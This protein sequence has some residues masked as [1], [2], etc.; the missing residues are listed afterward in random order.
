MFNKF[1]HKL[2]SMDPFATLLEYSLVCAL[3]TLLSAGTV[4]I[5]AAEEY[6]GGTAFPA[7]LPS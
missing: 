4:I 5:L 1:R 6:D 2:R 3:V 7:I